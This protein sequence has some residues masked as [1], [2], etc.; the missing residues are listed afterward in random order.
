MG[1]PGELE[2]ARLRRPGSL[3]LEDVEG[4]RPGARAGPALAGHYGRT[5]LRFNLV[6]GAGAGPWTGPP[7]VHCQ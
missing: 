1:R 6:V 4:A 3:K 5:S 2:R 7:G